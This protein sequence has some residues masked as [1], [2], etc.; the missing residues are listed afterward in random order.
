MCCLAEIFTAQSAN[1]NQS[2][3]E[4]EERLGFRRRYGNKVRALYEQETII[5]AAG[6]IVRPRTIRIADAVAVRKAK[7]DKTDP[8]SAANAGPAGK[9]KDFP[10]IQFIADDDVEH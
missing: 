3:T 1:A 7:F 4:Y 8:S 9:I 5:D 6:Q 2:K 10:R